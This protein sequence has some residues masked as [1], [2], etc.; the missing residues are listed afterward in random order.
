MSDTAAAPTAPPS[1]ISAEFP[2]EGK[3]IEV[4][5]SRMH[6]LEVGS[7]DPILILHGNPT[8]SYIWRNIIPHLEPLGRCIVPDL[9]GFGRSDKPEIQYHWSDHVHYLEG[10]IRRMGLQD[11]TLVLHDQGSGLGFHYASRNESN[12]RA[13]AFF[14]ALIRP[15]A[16][17]EFSLPEF[18]ELFRKFRT[19]GEGGLGWQMIVEQ[20][21]FIEQLL[22]QAA[23]R[24]LSEKEMSFYREPFPDAASRLPI[25]RFPRETAIGGEPPDVW[26]SVS[27]YSRWLQ[28]TSLPKLLLYAEPG[29]LITEEHRL[30]A[31]ENILGLETV[32]L[33]PGAHFL[34]ESSPDAIGRG[35][36]GWLRR[37]RG[38][39]PPSPGP[40]PGPT[41]DP[42]PGPGSGGGFP[43]APDGDPLPAEV[44]QALIDEAGNFN[45]LS[46]PEG[47]HGSGEGRP[48]QGPGGIVGWDVRE[49]LHRLEVIT[50]APSGRHPFRASNRMGE[51]LGTFQ[52]RWMLAPDD[53]VATPESVPP[54][55]ALDPSRSQR[56]VLLDG[57][58]RFGQRD[59]FRGF[60]AGHTLPASTPGSQ[61]KLLFLGAGTILDGFGSFAGHGEGTYLYCGSLDPDR[62]FTG[63]L[64]LRVM[65]P[66]G[67]IRTQRSLS[68]LEPAPWPE[69]GITYVL[70]RGEALPSDPV[71]PNLG[72]DGRPIGLIVE[73]GLRLMDVDSALGVVGGGDRR[74]R[75][76]YRLG[77]MVGR[78]T[79]HVVFDPTSAS[80][81]V[82]DPIPFTTWDELVFHDGG[83]NAIGTLHAD[84]SEG[85]VFNTRISGQP[86]IRFG[87]VGRILDG[88]GSFQGIQGLMTDNSLVAFTPH[89]SASVYLFRIEDPEGRFRDALTEG[90]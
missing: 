27:A 24:P 60:G 51:A 22:P 76:R 5:G 86:A 71:S 66:E 53:F 45:L 33:G 9:I 19:G 90:C 50:Q 65:D 26:E 42:A 44:L 85:R 32:S 69:E 14:E 46:I 49:S 1:G 6:Y 52:H 41:P 43:P 29:A 2:Y 25:W 63:N 78:I 48:I 17:D 4:H 87:G 39:S 35:I 72:P 82:L 57:E 55:T 16:W 67:T 61:G 75:T 81:T 12:V 47:A 11:I 54:P 56:V 37:L 88:T 38:E 64:F 36:A 18:R 77:Q 30:W 59:G 70:L 73:Q 80:G 20:N 68:S 89:V 83:G 31:Q 40:S 74:P 8:W 28:R 62:G 3:Y 23:G 21:V 79:A 58:C 34:Q 10:F 13:L 84:S 15:F 7:G